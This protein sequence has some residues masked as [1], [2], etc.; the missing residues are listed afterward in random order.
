[1]FV[2]PFVPQ[3]DFQAAVAFIDISGFT[4]LSER[5]VSEFGGLQCVLCFLP[6]PVLCFC[7]CVHFGIVAQQQ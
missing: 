5:L 2:F 7:F 4:K 3:E 1:M 6:L